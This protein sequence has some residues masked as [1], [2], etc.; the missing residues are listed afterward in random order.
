[1]PI[2]FLIKKLNKSQI[3]VADMTVTGFRASIIVPVDVL[4]L[5]EIVI[6]VISTAV[7]FF[8]IIPNTENNVSIKIIPI[9]ILPPDFN[10]V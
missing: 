8:S 6:W 5:L 9:T 3:F 1:M 7:N 10:L 4:R 2:L